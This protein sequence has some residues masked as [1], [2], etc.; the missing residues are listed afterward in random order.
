MGKHKG[1]YNYNSDESGALALGQL[2]FEEVTGTGGNIGLSGDKSGD[3]VFV[4][5]KAVMASAAATT[6]TEIKIT[7]QC[8]HGD[9]LG[10][11]FLVHGDIIWGCFNYVNIEAN[12]SSLMKLLVYKGK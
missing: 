7:A 8:L 9:D 3:N 2:G 1:L 12:G 11:T 4:A 5:I 6:T 10:D